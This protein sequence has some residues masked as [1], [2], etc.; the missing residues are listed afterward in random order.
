MMYLCDYVFQELGVVQLAERVDRIA[1]RGVGCVDRPVELLDGVV[2][3]VGAGNDVVLQLGHLLKQQFVA[4][5][6]PGIFVRL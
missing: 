5:E 2:D 1:Q 4:V 3:Q 6:L